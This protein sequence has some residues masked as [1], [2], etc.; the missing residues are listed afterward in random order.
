MRKMLEH[1]RP[2]GLGLACKSEQL[3]GGADDGG[4][5][6]SCAPLDGDQSDGE[7]LGV[8]QLGGVPVL[9]GD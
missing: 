2:D 8:A 5:Q 1:A 3:R 4:D 7:P 6:L 9:D